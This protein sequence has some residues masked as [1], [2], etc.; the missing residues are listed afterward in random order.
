MFVFVAVDVHVSSDGGEQHDFD[1]IEKVEM[2][3]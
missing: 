3:S 1:I 2:V